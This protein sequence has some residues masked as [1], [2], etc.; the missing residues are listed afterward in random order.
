MEE[1]KAEYERYGRSEHGDI[2]FGEESEGEGESEEEEEQDLGISAIEED[3]FFVR[4]RSNKSLLEEGYSE[5]QSK[6]QI[7]SRR[8]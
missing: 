3:P 1:I 2:L 7:E 4:E 5:E 8:N 6:S